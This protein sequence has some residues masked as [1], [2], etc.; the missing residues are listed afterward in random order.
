MRRAWQSIAAAGLSWLAGCTSLPESV[1]ALP[2]LTFTGAES[3]DSSRLAAVVAAEVGELTDARWKRT[4]VDD[5]AFA[6]ERFYDSQGFAFAQVDYSFD[7]G[8]GES[9]AEIRIV[10]GPRVTLAA[11]EVVGATSLD[12]NRVADFF[13]TPARGEGSVGPPWWSEDAL[14][15]AADALADHYYKNGWLDVRVGPPQTLLSADRLRA[16]VRVP[17]TEGRRSILVSVRVRGAPAEWTEPLEA[18]A[19]DALNQPYSPAVGGLVRAR[20]ADWLALR[21]YPEA[22][23]SS[24]PIAAAEAS[25]SAADAT[26]ARVELTVDVEMGSR[27]VIAAIEIRGARRT[28]RETVLELLEFAPGDVYSLERERN[29]F[30]RLYQ[31]GLFSSVQLSLADGEGE[32]RTLVVDLAEATG[33]EFFIEPGYGSYER[34][35][36]GLGWR[37]NNLFGTGRQLEAEARLADR[38]Q[39]GS[40][41]LVSP[42][43]LGSDVRS[44]I[45]LFSRR[46]EEPTFTSREDGAGWMFSRRF[47]ER[48]SASLGYQFRSTS[49]SDVDVVGP[50]VQALIDAVEISSISFSPTRD[51]RD[52][53]FAPTRGSLSKLTIEY[54]DATLGSELD[55]LRIALGHSSFFPVWEGGVLGASWRG[56]VIAPIHSSA[57]IPLQ[58]RYFN[59]GENTVRSFKEDRLGPTDVQGNALGGEAFHVFSLEL[60]QRL[61]GNL[62]A[63]LFFDLG[64]VQLDHTDFFD[65]SGFREG[66]GVGLRYNL[67]IGPIRLDWGVNPDPRDSESRSVL[68]FT[69]GMAF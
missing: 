52:S 7:D 9:R 60:R 68:H 36:V 57:A 63:A 26:N 53:V 6:V 64:N 14:A 24:P 47:G 40:V 29:S 35:R 2:P 27:V 43:F 20:L 55:F 61:R 41:S 39:S 10:E 5:A 38:A 12:S 49:A 59:G 58:E 46:R 32:S 21:G 44:A 50:T 28:R 69:V 17:V 25:G 1:A 30:R 65:D 56:A 16:S 33:S 13:P 3:F 34:W 66:L 15:S 18:R 19:R 31:S 22:V 62:D 23:L 8:D 45:S 11:L 54:A 51:S 48:W 4:A 37:W 42:R 67:P